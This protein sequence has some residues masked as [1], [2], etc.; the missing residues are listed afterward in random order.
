MEN[1]SKEIETYSLRIA[2]ETEN[3]TNWNNRGYYKMKQAINENNIDLLK[4][5]I[6][7]FEIAIK[8]CSS[9]H[10]NNIYFIAESNIQDAKKSLVSLR[11]KA[12]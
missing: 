11:Q 2:T 6:T 7:D 8:Y 1:L 4:E 5:S 9:I 12:E 10:R 3:Y